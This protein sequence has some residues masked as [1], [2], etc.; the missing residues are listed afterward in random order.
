[1][2]HNF[3]FLRNSDIHSYNTRRRNDFRLPLVKRNYGRQRPFYQCAK[4]W[5]LFSRRI[6]VL[7][8]AL[9]VIYFFQACERAVFYDLARLPGRNRWQ[10]HSQVC[11]LFVN[12]QQTSF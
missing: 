9:K 1:M 7:N 11:L 10:L 3:N 4:E 8:R 12:E 2:D 6:F 5:N